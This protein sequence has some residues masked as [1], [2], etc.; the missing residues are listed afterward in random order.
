MGREERVAG[1]GALLYTSRYRIIV[2]VY[3]GLGKRLVVSLC[4]SSRFG[5][6]H[7]GDKIKFFCLGN[8]IMKMR[9]V[10]MKPATWTQCPT[11]L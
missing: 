10:Y 6:M 4:N 2:I 1:V 5:Y 3:C 7:G 8:W 9:W 11:L